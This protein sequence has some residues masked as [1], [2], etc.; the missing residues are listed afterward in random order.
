MTH[1]FR[2]TWPFCTRFMLKPTVGIEL[3]HSISFETRL[4]AALPDLG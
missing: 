4:M 2:V 1:H 3:S